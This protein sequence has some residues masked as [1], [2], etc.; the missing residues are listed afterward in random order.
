MI[1][2]NFTYWNGVDPATFLNHDWENPS[3]EWACEVAIKA[4]AG[5]TLL[6]VGPGPGVDYGNHFQHA[7]LTGR[8]AYTGYEGSRTLYDAL[9]SRFRESAWENLTI[10]DLPP[11]GA[12]VVYARH[13]MEHQPALDPALGQLLN[14]ARRVVVLTWYRPPA[15]EAIVHIWEG[16]HCQTYERNQVLDVV[17]RAGFR[18]AAQRRFPSVAARNFRSGDEAWVLERVQ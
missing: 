14:A 9:R 7:V 6:E 3:R 17:A 8:V 2:P 11:S 16:V 1:S 18:I 12:D 15:R 5:G 4:A 13:V 10:A